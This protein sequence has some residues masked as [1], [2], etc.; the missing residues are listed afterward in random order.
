[1]ATAPAL[2]IYFR[3]DRIRIA[4]GLWDLVRTRE[5]RSPEARLE[6]C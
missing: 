3:R 1:M 2:V 6:F 4:A 5:M